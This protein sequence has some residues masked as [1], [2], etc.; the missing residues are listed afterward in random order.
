LKKFKNKRLL[1][2]PKKLSKIQG[3]VIQDTEVINYD[4]ELKIEHSQ[5]LSDIENLLAEDDLPLI[6]Q[7]IV[8][9]LSK[10]KSFI[11]TA[12]AVDSLI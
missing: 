8:A 5:A 7:L 4:Q 6:I 2:K 11:Y 3:R 1:E 12:F 10:L 9:L